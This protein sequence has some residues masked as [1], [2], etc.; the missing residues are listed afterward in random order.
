MHKNH[1]FFD[2]KNIGMPS[3]IAH[4]FNHRSNKIINSSESPI[5]VK[6]YLNRKK[7]FAEVFFRLAENTSLNPHCEKQMN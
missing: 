3:S 1:L 4:G 6:W 2:I 5:R 7:L